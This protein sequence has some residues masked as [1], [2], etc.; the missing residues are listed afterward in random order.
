MKP[1]DWISVKDKLPKL[2]ERVLVCRK[3]EDGSTYVDFAM[4]VSRE[5]HLHDIDIWYTEE[6]WDIE[7][8][9]HWQ[10]IVLPK[11]EKEN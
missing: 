2:E 11:K 4:L 6:G 5:M 7:D 10:K 9:T 8:V 3:L 1:T